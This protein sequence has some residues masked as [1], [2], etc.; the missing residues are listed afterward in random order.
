MVLY[1]RKPKKFVDM[2]ENPSSN[3]TRTSALQMDMREAIRGDIKRDLSG[4][5]FG[6]NDGGDVEFGTKKMIPSGRFTHPLYPPQL[7]AADKKDWLQL[8]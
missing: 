6:E 2:K 1:R 8:H 3:I 4:T 5:F 7:S